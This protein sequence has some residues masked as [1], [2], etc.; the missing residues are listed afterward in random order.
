MNI[1]VVMN[2]GEGQGRRS[3][4]GTWKKKIIKKKRVYIW[5]K[6][7]VSEKKNYIDI[8]VIVLTL[9]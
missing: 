7:N 2:V 6:F 4:L 3:K 9:W 5:P 8:D 1:N